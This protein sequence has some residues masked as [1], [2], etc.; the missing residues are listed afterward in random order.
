MTLREQYAG[1][2]AALLAAAP[3][4]PAAV[5]RSLAAAIE[6]E[7]GRVL[8]VHRGGEKLERSAAGASWRECE[9]RFSVITRGDVPE[10]DA[11]DVMEVAHPLIMT[12]KSTNLID[13]REVKTDEPKFANADGK[14]CMITTHY[15]LRYRT[16]PNSN[17][18]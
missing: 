3:G 17:S 2:L 4:F 7:K 14:A 6:R 9:M 18:L 12:F 1:E 11:D 10:K 15:L 13:V 8:V 5:E 16:A